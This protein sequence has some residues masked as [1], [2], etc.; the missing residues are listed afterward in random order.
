MTVPLSAKE[1]RYHFFFVKAICRKLGFVL[2]FKSYL[3]DSRAFE[4][5]LSAPFNR[6]NKNVIT[7]I[8]SHICCG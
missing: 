3:I 1:Q 5:S 4:R 8:I 2:S 6:L 7:A